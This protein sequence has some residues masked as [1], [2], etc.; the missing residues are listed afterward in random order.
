MVESSAHTKLHLTVCNFFDS[1]R[2][3]PGNVILNTLI[4]LFVKSIILPEDHPY[5]VPSGEINNVQCPL[6]LLYYYITTP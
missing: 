6:D 5:R 4:G 3:S 1:E 2:S